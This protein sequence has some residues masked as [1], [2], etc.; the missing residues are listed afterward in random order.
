MIILKELSRMITLKELEGKEVYF[1]PTGNYARRGGENI[2]GKILKVA[3]VNCT[4]QLE[5][6]CETKLRFRGKHLTNDHNCGYTVFESLQAIEDH[7]EA[8]SLSL[9]LARTLQYATAWNNLLTLEQLR[10]IY[11]IV[12][13][14][15]RESVDD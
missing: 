13:P 11:D 1:M 8:L 14:E 10:E 4:I 5:G 6:R 2:R 3:K 15:E 9:K 12:Y 7:E